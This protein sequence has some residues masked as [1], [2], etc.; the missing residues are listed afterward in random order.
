MSDHRITP[1][2]DW[3]YLSEPARI[4]AALADLL[5]QPD[6]AR[7]RQ[8]VFGDQVTLLGQ[9]GNACYIRAE[10]DNYHG[11]VPRS[12]VSNTCNPTHRVATLAT[13]IYAEPDFRSA[14]LMH[15]SFGSRLAAISETQDFVE[16]EEGH[17]P[18]QHLSNAT[19][20]ETNP[21]GLAMMFLGTPYLW[22]GNSSLGI[23]CSGLVQ[24]AL[25]ACGLP[26]PGD[27]DLQ[28]A[29]FGTPLA[30]GTQKQPGD[31]L[32]WKG[33]V[34]MVV[35]AHTLIH[36]NAHHMATRLENVNAALGRIS[37]LY[38]GHIRPY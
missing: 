32:F 13:H 9:K 11:F 5:D 16:T 36:A 1:N 22:G 20:F 35:D 37:D 27:S 18:K 12:A 7:D 25:L 2:P 21:V 14:N 3:S 33:H 24:T 23:D 4:S 34:A 31:L 15:L 26:C 29:S 8:L 10:K 30:D 38:L 19:E 6:G 28:W 17:V